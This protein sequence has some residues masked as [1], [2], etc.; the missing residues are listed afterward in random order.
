MILIMGLGA[1]ANAWEPHSSEWSRNF[2]CI[3]VDNRGAGKSPLAA[4]PASTA[5]MAQDTVRL[6]EALG[7]GPSVVVG[8]SMG[9]G[10]AQQLAL[11]RPDLVRKLVLVAPWARCDAYTR[12][13][14]D[15][16]GRVHSLGDARS[17]NELLRNTVWTPRWV[18]ERGESMEADLNLG[19]SMQSG[20]FQEQVRACQEHDVFA[21]LPELRVPTLVTIG[22]RD[23]FIHP[24]LSREVVAQIPGAVAHVFEGAGH[25]HHWEEL[26]KFNELIQNWTK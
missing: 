16:L 23:V 13:V 11:A 19:L 6:M 7:L 21:R 2:R 9:A 8:I 24:D 1:A 25:V 4:E 14:L 5:N 15:V 3:S 22:D 26:Q 18:N 17:F 10:I 20:A 12:S